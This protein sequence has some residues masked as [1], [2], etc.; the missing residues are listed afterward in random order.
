[1]IHK[2]TIQFSILLFMGYFCH[3]T[4]VKS[5]PTKVDFTVHN[6]I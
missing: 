5:K 2:N 3:Y 4:A 6:A 1:M